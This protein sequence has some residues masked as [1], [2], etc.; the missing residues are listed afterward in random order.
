[1]GFPSK[2]GVVKESV[3]F[4]GYK[5]NRYPESKKLAHRRYFTKAGGGLLH[6]HVWESHNGPIPPGHH[7]HHKDG[8]FSNNDISNLECLSCA[9]H[10]DEHAEQRRSNA[11]RPEQLAH[12]DAVRHKAAAWHSSPEGL[13][14]HQA[15]AHSSWAKR[16][17][18]EHVCQ[19]CGAAFQ[20][21]KTSKVFFCSGR[22]SARNWRK[23]HPDYYSSKAKTKRLQSDGRALP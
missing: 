2:A 20:S 22:C 13:A 19:E 17:P 18:V 23:T 6:R 5:Y 10:L 11:K 12:L 16:K 7:V 14:W 3:Y 21:L 9:K 8:N 4:N 15:H 1:M